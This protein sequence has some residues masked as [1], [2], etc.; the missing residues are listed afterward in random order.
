MTCAFLRRTLH[1]RSQARSPS[2][3]CEPSAKTC[4]SYQGIFRDNGQEFL[5]TFRI[6]PGTQDW[7]VGIVVPRAF[8]LGKLVAIRNRLLA[9]SLGV[10][11]LL[12]VAGMA[13]LR[14]VKRAQG[15]ITRESL[16]MNAFEFSPA[17][18]QSAFRDLTQ[19]LES[20]EKA[21]KPRWASWA[22]TRRWIL[23]GNSIARKASP[24]L[25]AS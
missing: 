24:S 20:L 22:S 2:P 9:V 18:T 17:P 15:Q 14:S 4:Q 12:V 16:K 5:T 21:K 13:I 7:L 25:V 6:L 23:C 1:P 10:M 3:S 8:Y 11:L 19:V